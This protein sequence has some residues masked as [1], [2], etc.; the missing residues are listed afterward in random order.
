MDKLK[1]ISVL[2]F[3]GRYC[4]PD[5]FAPAHAGLATSSLGNPAVDDGMADFTLG[6]IVGRLHLGGGQKTEINLGSLATESPRQ[7]L[8][9]RMVRRLLHP[10]QKVVLDLFGSSGKTFC[11]Q[12]L[13]AIQRIKQLFQRFQQLLAPVGQFLSFMFSQKP[14]LTD[15][16]GH[17]VLYQGVRQTIKFAIGPVIIAPDNPDTY[18]SRLS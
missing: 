12:H 6:T 17:T 13:M 2:L 3:A 16:M 10:A 15:Q 8:G 9:Q 1:D 5:A 11:R 7:F 14:Y 4:C 18:D